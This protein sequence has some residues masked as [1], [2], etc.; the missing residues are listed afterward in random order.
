MVNIVTS[1]PIGSGWRAMVF[2]R[3]KHRPEQF[4]AEVR[5]EIL[6]LTGF[7]WTSAGVCI[8]APRAGFQSHEPGIV[9]RLVSAS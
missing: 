4:F 9:T 5:E 3:R 7:L 6:F 1:F 2:L 8:Y